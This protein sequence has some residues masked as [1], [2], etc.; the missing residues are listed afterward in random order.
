MANFIQQKI[1]MQGHYNHENKINN[2][3]GNGVIIKLYSDFVLPEV[4]N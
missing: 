3:R 2:R 1:F 4:M